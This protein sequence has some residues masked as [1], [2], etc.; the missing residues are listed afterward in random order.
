MAVRKKSKTG[1]SKGE[2]LLSPETIEAI[3]EDVGDLYAEHEK[4][5]EA[6]VSDSEDSKIAL[7]FSVLIDKS[8][9]APQ[10]KTRLR[11]SQSVTDERIRTLTDPRQPTLFTKDELKLNKS[12]AKKSASEPPVEDT[13]PGAAAP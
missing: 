1:K 9:S 6:A 3:K 10:V 8:E 4:D 13:D 7:S 5:I 2:P 11:Y 12:K